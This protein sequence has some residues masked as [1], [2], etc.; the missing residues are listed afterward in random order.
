MM[1]PKSGKTNKNRRQGALANVLV[2]WQKGTK[3][4]GKWHDIQCGLAKLIERYLVKNDN[5]DTD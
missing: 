5:S 4:N 2:L 1:T 3:P